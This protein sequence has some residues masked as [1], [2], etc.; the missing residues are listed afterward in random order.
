VGMLG[1][2][3]VMM[4]VGYPC[5][6]RRPSVALENASS[7]WRDAGGVDDGRL[8]QP[9]KGKQLR[10]IDVIRRQR[11]IRCAARQRNFLPVSVHHELGF[12][13][14]AQNPAHVA[15]IVR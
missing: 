4:K 8:S 12:S 9:L 1:A 2:Q 15:D 11:C 5:P 13:V 10:S 14:A 7:Q 3:E 6:H